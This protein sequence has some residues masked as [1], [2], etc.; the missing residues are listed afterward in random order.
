MTFGFEKFITKSGMPVITLVSGITD[1]R[2][3]LLTCQPGHAFNLTIHIARECNPVADEQ[4]D[5]SQSIG[6]SS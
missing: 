2:I 5:C 1:G 4:Q 3:C 6:E